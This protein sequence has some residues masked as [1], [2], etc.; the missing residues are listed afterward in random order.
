MI[1]PEPQIF[2][3]FLGG[4]HEL[5]IKVETPNVTF[6]IKKGS[7]HMET[8]PAN[9]EVTNP[10]PAPAPAPAP[11]ATIKPTSFTTESYDPVEIPMPE[12]EVDVDPVPMPEL[13]VD[14]GTYHPGFI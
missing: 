14:T 3:V 13:E 5:K 11:D 12:G 9:M 4:C 6:S 2:H 1:N 7:F 8:N 10:A